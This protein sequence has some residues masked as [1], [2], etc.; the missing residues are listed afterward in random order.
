MT[1]EHTEPHRTGEA[2]PGVGG[3]RGLPLV[4]ISRF[5]ST[6]PGVREAFLDDLR[7]AGMPE[8]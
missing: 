7:T 6:E 5:R 3:V 2:G 8:R 1:I 4:D